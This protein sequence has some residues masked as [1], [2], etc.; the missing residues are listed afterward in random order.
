MRKSVF[1]LLIVSLTGAM[2][3]SQ[4]VLLPETLEKEQ[5]IEL[6]LAN[7]FSIEVARNNLEIAETMS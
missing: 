6:M 7:N 2:G 3:I 5:A 4:E 1:L